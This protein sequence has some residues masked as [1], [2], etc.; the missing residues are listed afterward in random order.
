MNLPPSFLPFPP[1]RGPISVGGQLH[2]TLVNESAM[3]ELRII[4]PKGSSSPVGTDVIA[5]SGLVWLPPA[6]SVSEPAGT[7][8]SDLLEFEVSVSGRGHRCDRPGEVRGVTGRGQRYDRGA[9]LFEVW[10]VYGPAD[11]Y[12]TIALSAYRAL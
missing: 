4:K 1:P 9:H 6:G 8:S 12:I 2:S 3:T 5:I 10:V 11:I 7:N